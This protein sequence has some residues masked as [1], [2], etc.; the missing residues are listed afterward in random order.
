[1]ALR[2]IPTFDDTPEG[3]KR[4]VFFAIGLATGFLSIAAATAA[5][6]EPVSSPPIAAVLIIL[7]S[8]AFGFSAMTALGRFDWLYAVE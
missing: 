7:G 5:L 4:S 8:I 3:Q 2:L 6:V 1:M